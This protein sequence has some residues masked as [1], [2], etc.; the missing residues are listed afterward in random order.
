MTIV[1]RYVNKNVHIIQRFIGVQHVSSPTAL[2]FKAAIDKFFSKHGLSISRFRRQ[3]YDGASNMKG[4]FNGL[5]ALVLKENPYAFY[6]DCFAHQLQLA[7]VAVAKQ[8]STNCI[9][10]I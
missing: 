2:S 8:A 7:L 9:S 1:L 6:V 3:G 10:T 4:E 5:K